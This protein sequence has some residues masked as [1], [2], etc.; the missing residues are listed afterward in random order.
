MVNI[1]NHS[2]TKA[3]RLSNYGSDNQDDQERYQLMTFYGNYANN[4]CIISRNKAQNLKFEW[5]VYF[6]REENSV[7]YIEIVLN[8]NNFYKINTSV[9]ENIITDVFVNNQRECKPKSVTKLDINESL[10]KYG[11]VC[12]L[13]NS[14]SDLESLQ[15]YNMMFEDVSNLTINFAVQE[16]TVCELHVYQTY[17]S[18]SSACGSPDIPLHS[19]YTTVY[20]EDKEEQAGI[21]FS[22]QC[23][24]GF[25][26]VG[27]PVINCEFSTMSLI[28]FFFSIKI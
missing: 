5:K 3:Y 15:F 25:K 26:L 27:N 23:N 16:I 12:D 10:I 4:E 18:R 22:F 7:N 17:I 8:T 6:K 20:T 11:F 14:N 21:G 13:K 1:K 9:S 2:I 19:N 24:P 28:Q